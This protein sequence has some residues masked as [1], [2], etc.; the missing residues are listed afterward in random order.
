VTLTFDDVLSAS[1]LGWKAG[2]KRGENQT[3]CLSSNFVLFDTLLQTINLKFFLG[4][5]GGTEGLNEKE[6]SRQTV[7]CGILTNPLGQI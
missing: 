2:E 5:P 1:T 3:S 6:G 7:K 4:K